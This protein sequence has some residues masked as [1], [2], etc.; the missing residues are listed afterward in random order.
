MVDETGKQ[1]GVFPIEEAMNMARERDLDLVEI[2]EKVSPPICK[3][4]DYGKYLYQLSKKERGQKTKQKRVE[5]KGV[6]IR[7]ITAKHDLELRIKQAEEFLKEGN[8][9]KIEMILRGREKMHQDLARK[10]IKEFISSIPLET[11]VEQE[12]KG[13]R[14]L[15]VIINRVK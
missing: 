4:I 15:V 8:K 13:P 1:V 10:K 11:A 3:I 9:V 2:T 12:L 5:V 14:G 7:P 6:R